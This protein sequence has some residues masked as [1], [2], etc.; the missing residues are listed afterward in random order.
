MDVKTGGFEVLINGG[1]ASTLTV[2]IRKFVAG[3]SLMF[4]SFSF[5]AAASKPNLVLITLGSTRADRMGF[6]GAKS[7][8]TPNLD[9]LAGESIVFEHAYAQAPGSVVSHATILS[10]A[11]PQSTG[12][13][14]IGGTLSSALPYLPELLKTQGYRTAAF[15]GSSDLDPWNGLAQGLDRGFQSYDAGVR[16]AS[17]GTSAS[18]VQARRS[19][20]ANGGQRSSP[21]QRRPD[22]VVTSAAAWLTNNTQAPFFLWIQIDPHSAAR[23]YDAGIAAAD[24]AIGKLL[25]TLHQQKL[26]GTTAVV[27]AASQ[28]ESLGAH[29][30]ETHG[31]F[32]Y[33]ETIRVPLVVRLPEAHPAAKR[34]TAKVRL[35]DIAPTLLEIAAI[36]VP[37]QMQGQSLLRIA[38]STSSGGSG[39]QP[40]YSRSDLP[41]R[42]FGWSPLESWR[43]GKYL[44]I[45]APKPELY[46]LTAD[47]GTAH[48]LAQSSKATL[49][50]MA[51]QLDSFDRHF[52]GEAGKASAELSSSE[53]QKL[54]SLGYIGLQ[55]SSG[56]ATSVIGTD[57]KDKIATANKVIEATL[58]REQSKPDLAI[59]RA[60]AALEPIVSAD[61]NLYLAQYTLGAA[62]ARKAQ[63][64]EA[65]KHLHKAI[66]LQPDSAWAHYEI[67][68]SLVKTEDFKTAIVHL[69]IATGRL[70]AFAP[71]HISLAEAYEHMG[72][73]EDAER[74]RA[75]PL[76]QP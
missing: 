64:A 37:S 2:M 49:D 44:Y 48:N 16:P 33:D 10:G 57:P 31:I 45:R 30:E 70:P 58:A 75:R 29:G 36:P 20:A 52:S 8:L 28:G 6:L 67:G 25:A 9:R 18:P 7:A 56:S 73:T 51:A 22:Q 1:A 71:A 21:T 76:K 5:A 19:S 63:Y 11:Y 40:V 4:V 65:V 24:T 38:K 59:A 66:E 32:L 68:A 34:V 42:G 15:V 54:A 39:E 17:V 41:Q 13:S 60:V 14:D 47:P 46:D 55:K 27:V 23:S 74:E 50:T 12:M 72:R 69:E 3:V 53:M 62:L 35:V 26:D 43:A 61:P